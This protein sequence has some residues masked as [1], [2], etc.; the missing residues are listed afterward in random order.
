MSSPSGPVVQNAESSS[1]AGS[2][3]VASVSGLT[4]SFGK[5][6]VSIASALLASFRHAAQKAAYGLEV[7]LVLLDEAQ[8]SRLRQDDE[9][10]TLDAVVQDARR[11]P[12]R[13]AVVFADDHERRPVDISELP[14]VVGAAARAP[15]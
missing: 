3:V 7:R 10:A 1:C 11:A 14:A 13:G 6:A 5:A 4:V 8:V 9:L 12:R 15:G 2:P